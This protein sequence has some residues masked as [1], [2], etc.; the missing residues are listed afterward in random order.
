MISSRDVSGRGGLTVCHQAELYDRE[1]HGN[2]M[3]YGNKFV[4]HLGKIVAG[5]YVQALI[6]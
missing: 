5:R 3:D 1:D 2:D 4:G 6:K